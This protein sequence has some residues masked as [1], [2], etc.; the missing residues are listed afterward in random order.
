MVQLFKVILFCSLLSC[1]AQDSI[2]KKFKMNGISLVSI[3]ETIDSLAVFPLL[4]VNANWV[5]IIPFAFMSDLNSSR[6]SCNVKRQWKGERIDGV[7]ESIQLMQDY[8][9]K[10]M[11]K[12]QIWIGSGGFT[13]EIF[14]KSEEDWLSFQKDYQNYIMSFVQ[15][16]AEYNI[17][18]ICIGTEL[19]AFVANRPVFWK[20]LIQEIKSVY[21][22]ELIYA[23]NW[24]CYQEVSFWNELDYIGIDAYFPISNI[25]SPSLDVLEKGW[26][27]HH[28]AIDS[29]SKKYDKQIV[30]TEYGYRSISKCA[31]APWDYSL[32][33]EVNQVAQENALKILYKVFWDKDSFAG[34]FLWKWYP[35]HQSAGGE[36]NTTF[37]VQNKSAEKLVQSVYKK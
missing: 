33:G 2:P 35:N 8:G 25:E 15:I 10:V 28:K 16:A 21:S 4:K 26:E 31:K 24:D 23:A 30:F 9:L 36:K 20:S 37:T 6:L 1:H 27:S 34:G 11:L 14:M 12:P 13:G 22:G 18:M 3:N 29:I 32:D 19:K 17:E 5:S 7:L